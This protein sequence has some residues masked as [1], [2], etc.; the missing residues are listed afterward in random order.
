MKRLFIV[1]SLAIAAIGCQKTEI[2]NEVLTPIGFNTEIGKQTRAIVDGTAATDDFGVYSY[3]YDFPATGNATSSAVMKNQ[4][5]DKDGNTVGATYYWPNDPENHIN[6]YAYSP[7]S[8]NA[9]MAAN[10]EGTLTLTRYKH[11]K[12]HGA[13]AV[14]F[15]VATPVQGATF[16]A[17]GNGVPVVFHHEMTKVKFQVVAQP[18]D[19]VTF[20]L[21]SITFNDAVQTADYINTS[22]TA[23][24]S[25]RWSSEEEKVDIIAFPLGEETNATNVNGTVNTTALTMIPITAGQ[26]TVVYTIQANGVSEVVE[27]PISLSNTTAWAANKSIIYKFSIGLNQIE[28]TPSVVQ[29]GDTDA[30]G[31][32]E[33][34]E[35]DE[36]IVVPVGE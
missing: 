24:A 1:A 23:F 32:I 4:Q 28:F 18:V 31:T 25:G 33:E 10:G 5:V 35:G 16:A 21:N 6:F 27:Q 13:N 29:W 7:Y 8:I 22:T 15:M 26:I 30:D 9:Q 34:G 19:G 17:C 11:E 20:T 3:L 36:T 2:Q 14:D 12:Y